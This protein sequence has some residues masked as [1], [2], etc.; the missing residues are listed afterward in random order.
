MCTTQPLIVSYQAK[1]QFLSE[2][3]LLRIPAPTK[4]VGDIHGQV[5]SIFDRMQVL[6]V[7]LCIRQ[8]YDLLRVFDYCGF[9][10]EQNFLF[11]GDYVDRGRQG[12][13]CICLLLAYKVT[14][15]L[16]I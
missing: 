16:L 15:L 1:D 13:E 8:Y 4:L 10:D 7:S 6:T 3:S 2:P 12:L 9:P 14:F 5:F 11:L